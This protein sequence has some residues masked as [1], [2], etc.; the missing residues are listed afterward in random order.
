M[1]NSLRAANYIALGLFGIG[2]I[3]LAI[4]QPGSAIVGAF[5]LVPFGLALLAARPASTRLAAWAAVISNG[6]WALL[7]IGVALVVAM[8][9]GGTPVAIPIA[10]LIATP[11]IL[12]ALSM[13]NSLKQG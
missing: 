4:A 13:R 11:C 10:M 12:N 1:N 2:V 8:G 5:N 3:A 9:L 6:L 7:Y